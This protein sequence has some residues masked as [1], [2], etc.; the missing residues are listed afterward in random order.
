MPLLPVEC[1]IMQTQCSPRGAFIH[2]WNIPGVDYLHPAHCGCSLP[3]DDCSLSPLITSNFP[4]P[5]STLFIYLAT[6][7][8]YR[9]CL[10]HRSNLSCSC[11]NAVSF[12]P[13]CLARDWTR[14]SA[15]T[16]A[17]A[18]RF[19]THCPTV[20]TPKMWFFL[21]QVWP[22]VFIFL[23]LFSAV[24]FLSLWTLQYFS[25]AH[26]ILLTTILTP[27]SSGIAQATCACQAAGTANGK[28]EEEI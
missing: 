14:A 12:N 21:T 22:D 3:Q 4:H 9:S 2:N 7:E 24:F 25:K 15:A 19:L 1:R 11:S 13:L 23:S 27:Q 20:R 18:V 28:I 8:A 10:G 17:T 5:E 6:P 16:H 26:V